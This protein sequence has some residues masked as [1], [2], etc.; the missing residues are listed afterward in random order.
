MPTDV[1]TR[2]LIDSSAAVLDVRGVDVNDAD[3]RG[4]TKLH[5]GQAAN[6]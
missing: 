5:R 4:A 6:E 1:H 3:S 2:G